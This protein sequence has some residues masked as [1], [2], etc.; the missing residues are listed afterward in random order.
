MMGEK[1]RFEMFEPFNW[2]SYKLRKVTYEKGEFENV[3]FCLN[4]FFIDIY[5]V[6]KRLKS[7]K[8]NSNWQ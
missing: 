2:S 5:G 8:R 7:V 6:S 1:L 4:L 3:S